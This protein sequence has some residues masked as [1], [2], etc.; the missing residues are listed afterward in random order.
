MLTTYRTTLAVVAAL[1]LTACAPSGYRNSSAVA[2]FVE[3]VLPREAYSEVETISLCNSQDGELAITVQLD[4]GTV[5]HYSA[6]DD[7][8]AL[9]WRNTQAQRKHTLQQYGA[10]RMGCLGTYAQ[11]GLQSFYL[12]GAYRIEFIL[13]QVWAHVDAD[14]MYRTPFDGATKER[15]SR[16]AF[17][18]KDALER[19]KTFTPVESTWN[20]E[21]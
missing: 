5:Y 6:E 15:L 13:G 4:G 9:V 16:I 11:H 10:P 1:S 14:V 19:Q 17:A 21:G 8:V 20:A 12:G 2:D 18:V 3:Q 7:K